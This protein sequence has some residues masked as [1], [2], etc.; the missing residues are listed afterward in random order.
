MSTQVVCNPHTK[1][2]LTKETEDAK[3]NITGVVCDHTGRPL[4]RDEKYNEREIFMDTMSG[5]YVMRVSHQEAAKLVA[6]GEVDVYDGI[7]EVHGKFIDAPDFTINGRN[8]ERAKETET[9]A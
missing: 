6:E 2:I 8:G 9:A 7:G 1:H 3:G 4:G 5:D